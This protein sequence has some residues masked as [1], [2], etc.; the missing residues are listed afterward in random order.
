MSGFDQFPFWRLKKNTPRLNSVVDLG[1]YKEQLE[2]GEPDQ[3]KMFTSFYSDGVIWP[4]GRKEQVD[5]VIFATG[6]KNKLSHLEATGGIDTKGEPI[7]EAGIST[8]VPG[9][10]YVGIEG[11]R[12]VASATLRGVAQMRNLWFES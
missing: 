5:T 11:Q 9:L 12:S 6:Y 10:Y 1:H 3:V 7:H 2:R 4:D 8:V